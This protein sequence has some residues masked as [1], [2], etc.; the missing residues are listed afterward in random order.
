LKITNNKAP[1]QAAYP[2]GLA[3]DFT[4]QEQ[5]VFALLE[6]AARTTPHAPYLNFLGRTHTYGYIMTLA[7]QFAAGLQQRGLKKGDRVG[8][9]LPNCPYYVAAYYG[10]LKAGATIVNFNPLYTEEELASQIKD[11]HTKL[12]VTLDVKTIYPKLEAALETTPLETI[13]LCSLP[14][15]LPPLKKWGLLLLKRN[16]LVTGPYPGATLAWA[17][18]LAPDTPVTP[19]TIDPAQDVALIQY[20]GGTTGVPKGAMLTHANITGNTQQIQLWLGE[21]SE[22]GERLIAVLPFFHVFSMTVALNLGTA[23]GAEIILLPRFELKD[24]LKT[25]SRCRPTIFP[26]V[27]TLFNAISGCPGVEKHNLSSI[28]WCISGG[29]PLP[30]Q[31][32]EAFEAL[33]GARLVE[34]YGLTEASPV[35]HCNPRHTGNRDGSIGLPLPGTNIEIRNLDDP[36]KTMPVG[37]RG[38]VVVR[39]PQVMAGYWNRPEETAKTLV[40]GWLHTGDIGHMDS[41]GYTYI[42]D[43]LKE[44]ILV[45]GYNVY[46]RIIEEVLYRHPHVEEA[47]VIPVADAHKGEAPK[48][49]VKMKNGAKETEHDI[50]NYARQHLNPIERPVAVEFRETLPKTLIG[51]LSKKELIE[52]ERRKET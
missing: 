32:K 38:E 33:T 43:R 12:M 49:F 21:L 26:G 46:P 28:R 8:L 45:N 34:G 7:E 2:K 15:A 39:G 52:E 13:V 27:P 48:A 37:E 51:K 44:V 31:V 29:A 22:E 1:W 23:I 9:C 11:S 30:A 41:D 16:Q 14:E 6:H 42:T 25:I 10:A 24:L 5:P 17:D 4:P 3:W 40:N 47:I 20:T 36:T 19:V 35:T 18:F 50:L